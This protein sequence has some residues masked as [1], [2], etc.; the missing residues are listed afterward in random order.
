MLKN[1]VIFLAIC[2]AVSI[3]FE[4]VPKIFYVNVTSSLPQGVYVRVPRREITKG[5]YIV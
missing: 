4:I 3:G 1:A 2:I 5:D